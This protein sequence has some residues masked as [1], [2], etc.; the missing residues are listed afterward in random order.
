MPKVVVVV[1]TAAAGL[2]ARLKDHLGAFRLCPAMAQ[3]LCLTGPFQH[4]EKPLVFAALIVPHF[5]SQGL[6]SF[7]RIDYSI[8]L[9]NDALARL[10][11]SGNGA[12]L[13]LSFSKLYFA[14]LKSLERWTCFMKF[15]SLPRHK[16]KHTP[17][18][19]VRRRA[20]SDV[21]R[22]TLSQ[23]ETIPLHT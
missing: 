8:E 21:G 18:L 5:L 23:C 4:E 7:A 14:T 22:S 16:R 17:P 10:P 9:H 12:P 20:I 2:L 6:G 1:G 13:I 11:K 3:S 15:L 19:T